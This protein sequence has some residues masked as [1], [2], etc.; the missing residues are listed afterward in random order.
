MG[1][2]LEELAGVPFLGKT[3][4]REIYF[5]EFPH[6]N[7]PGG[8]CRGPPFWGNTGNSP[9]LILS[10]VGVPWRV[11]GASCCA[12]MNKALDA[13]GL[14]AHMHMLHS[15]CSKS[16]ARPATNRRNAMRR[17]EANAKWGALDFE[18]EL[19]SIC[20][21]MGPLLTSYSL[22]AFKKELPRSV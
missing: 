14:K 16:S 3:P 8:T 4:A 13:Q 17:A 15:S 22:K 5:G 10:R 2:P 1:V 21:C 18:Q 6:G 12:W 20:I 11:P 19:C 7:S 9:L